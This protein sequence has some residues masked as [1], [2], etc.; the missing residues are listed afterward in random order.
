MKDFI[1]KIWDAIVAWL[2]G[3]PSDKKWH[4]AAGF[5]FA[6]LFG[7]L[8]NM[9]ACILPAI[10]AGFIK[11]FFDLWTT[12]QWDWKDFLATAIGGVLPQLFVILNML[13][14]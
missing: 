4:F 12:D 7:M 2:L 13:L 1:R 6:T 14:Y 3:I 5:F 10:F 11:E 9:K 8:F